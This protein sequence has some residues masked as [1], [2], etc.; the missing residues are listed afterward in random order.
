MNPEV[1]GRGVKVVKTLGAVEIE[2]VDI[3]VETGIFE[4]VRR[5]LA[6][7]VTAD[8]EVDEGGCVLKDILDGEI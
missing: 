1:G 4:T 2:V 6:R 3:D 8:F 7:R 5:V